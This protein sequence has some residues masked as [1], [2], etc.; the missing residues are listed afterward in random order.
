M[1]KIDSL[2]VSVLYYGINKAI[3]DVMGTGGMVLGRRTSQEMI[4]LLKDLGVLKEN[5]TDEDIEKL[6]VEV[7]GLSE[8]IV[9]ENN[10]DEVIFHVINPTLDIFLGKII[11]ENIE[12]YVCPFIHLL[13]R[14]Y[15]EDKDYKLMLKGVIPEHNKA[16]I[17]F[18]KIR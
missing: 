11:E 12:P 7:F 2:F 4:K 10:D 15:E 13:S 16:S 18:K 9:I 5:M 3:V 6:F 8:N 1:K 17:V 14:V